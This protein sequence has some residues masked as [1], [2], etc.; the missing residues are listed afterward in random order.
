MEKWELSGHFPGD[1]VRLGR[2]S[3]HTSGS[4]PVTVTRTSSSWTQE[5]PEPQSTGSCKSL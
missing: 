3:D 2:M 4:D 5:V 1:G